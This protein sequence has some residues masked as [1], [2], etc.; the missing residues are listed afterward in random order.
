MTTSPVLAPARP[1]PLPRPL[2]AAGPKKV[3]E[4]IAL[5]GYVRTASFEAKRRASDK[6]LKETFFTPPTAFVPPQKET[7][8][9]DAEHPAWQRHLL[10]LCTFSFMSQFK[11]SEPFL[12][13]FLV[14]V[15]GLTGHQVVNQ[16]FDL[17]VYARMPCMCI[18]ALAS[19]RGSSRK[20]LIVGATCGLVTVIL[21]RFGELLLEQQAAQFT[22]A[23]AFASRVVCPAIVISITSPARYQQSVHLLKA[24]MLLSNFASAVLGEALRDYA[25]LP[26][27]FLFDVSAFG[28]A[29]SLVC[30]MLMPEKGAPLQPLETRI[31]EEPTTG[32]AA[33]Q[34]PAEAGRWLFQELILDLRYSLGLPKVMWWTAWALVMNPVHGITMTYWQGL[35]RSKGILSDHN[36][37][38]LACMYLIAALFTIY[39]GFSPLFTG[40]T[41]Q[42]V[43]GSLLVG[44]LLLIQVCRETEQLPIYGWLL[45][46]Q[47]LFEVF[48]A[49]GTYQVGSEV[50]RSGYAS[51]RISLGRCPSRRP[52]DEIARLTTLFSATAI[53]SGV[54]QN[55]LLWIV[56]RWRVMSFRFFCLAVGLVAWS[57]LLLV[58]RGMQRC[59]SRRGLGTEEVD[60]PSATAPLLLDL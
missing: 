30:A 33:V 12:V 47:V 57:C 17:F 34:P 50:M 21:T 49:V 40:S 11:P 58:A 19:W 23:A 15:K 44:G 1:P 55:V 16:V 24:M 2:G 32:P 13:D 36:G 48:S 4:P 29:I 41:H 28:Q 60:G 53:M 10:L 45:L 8:V 46:F 5:P 35:V 43:T 18:V 56:L 39:S 14:G 27:T 54:I 20:I 25:A 6:D 26:L 37:T 9:E 7:I 51:A 52:N 59:A 42:L 22:V 38:M 3:G 31:D